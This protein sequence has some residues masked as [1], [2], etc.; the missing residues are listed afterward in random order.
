VEL[1]N[2]IRFGGPPDQV[3]ALFQDVE[4]VALCVPGAELTEAVDEN[5]FKGKLNVKLGPVALGFA[6]TVRRERVDEENRLIVLKADGSE[7]KGK[8]SASATLTSVLV[9]ADGGTDVKITTELLISGGLSQFGRS[10]IGDV[11]QR[12]ATQFATCLTAQ[13]AAAEEGSG[14]EARIEPGTPPRDGAPQAKPIGGIR[15]ALWAVWRAIV[16]LAHRVAA[17]FRNG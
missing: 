2:A 10:M 7:T 1:E 17:A 9:P 13:I 12:I 8:G 5:T 6:G 3:W 4:R 15:L 16:R 14:A 11:F